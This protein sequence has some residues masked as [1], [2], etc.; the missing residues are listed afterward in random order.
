MYQSSQLSKPDVQAWLSGI[1][2]VELILN[3][4]TSLVA[5]QQFR[6]G[7]EMVGL[8]RKSVGL[9]HNHL[10]TEIWPTVFTGLS[11]ITNRTTPSHRDRL[12]RSLWYD[13]LFSCGTDK[14]CELVV[15]DLGMKVRYQPG[16]VCFISGTSLQHSVEGWTSGN[17]VAYAHYHR[18]HV[19]ERLQVKPGD[20]PFLQD[21]TSMMKPSFVR[22]NDKT[23]RE[24]RRTA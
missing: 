17:W 23:Y 3:A 15:K 5:P 7:V 6:A 2:H 4:T 21:Y 20:C 8:V 12:G 9:K 14:G 18:V 24:K 11:V 22:R 16:D 1:G 19:S 13:L 10:K